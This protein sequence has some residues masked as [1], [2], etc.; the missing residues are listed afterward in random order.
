MQ[1]GQTKIEIPGWEP[2]GNKI[3]E[4]RDYTKRHNSGAIKCSS[5]WEGHTWPCKCGGRIHQEFGDTDDGGDY[6]LDDVCDRCGLDYEFA[7]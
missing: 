1:T 6:W 7:D 2:Y 3:F 5:C 4:A